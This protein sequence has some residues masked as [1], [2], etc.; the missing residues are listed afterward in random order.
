MVTKNTDITHYQIF[1]MLDDHGK[2]LDSLDSKVDQLSTDMNALGAKVDKIYN[3]V[4]DIS[5]NMKVNMDEQT[6]MSRRVSDH[7]ERLGVVEDALSIKQP[8]E[9]Y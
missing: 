4:V 8:V 5:G 7:E 9:V 6:F 2:R 1:L 3:L